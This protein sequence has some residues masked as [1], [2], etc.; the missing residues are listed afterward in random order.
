MEK[1]E[2]SLGDTERA[3]ALDPNLDAGVELNYSM[4]LETE[5]RG[6]EREEARRFM[7]EGVAIDQNAKISKKLKIEE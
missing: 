2:S 1:S 3:K 7:N 6:Q 4:Y 5:L